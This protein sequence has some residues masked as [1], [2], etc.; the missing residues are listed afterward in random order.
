MGALVRSNASFLIPT[1]SMHSLDLYS[2]MSFIRPLAML[3]S[4]SEDVLPLLM[5]NVVVNF[6]RT[7]R[8]AYTK[9]AEYTH[10]TR[11]FGTRI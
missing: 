6:C 1:L 10:C 3:I 9:S 5:K 8:Y 4:S 2:G 7:S 11:F